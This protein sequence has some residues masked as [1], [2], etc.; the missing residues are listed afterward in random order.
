MNGPTPW[1]GRAA[2]IRGWERQPI[3][4]LATPAAA[5]PTHATH[6]RCCHLTCHSAPPAIHPV[7]PRQK[8]TSIRWLQVRLR[9][10]E[11]G[12]SF[13]AVP[14][15]LFCAVGPGL[16]VCVSPFPRCLRC[17][18]P[19]GVFPGCREPR[20]G[21]PQASPSLTLHPLLFISRALL[22]SP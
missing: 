12:L 3:R 5:K 7:V 18:Q 6:A 17:P 2:P 19:P 15:K 13:T 20:L 4:S 21:S 8:R 11:R 22:H 14:S 10:D 16:A 9:L 1:R